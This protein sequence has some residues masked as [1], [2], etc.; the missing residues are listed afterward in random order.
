MTTTITLAQSEKH[1]A[2]LAATC[3]LIADRGLHNIPMSAIAKKAKMAAGTL[4][5]YFENKDVLINELFLYLKRESYNYIVQRVDTDQ[6]FDEWL[7]QMWFASARRHLDFPQAFNVI[8][9]CELSGILSPDTLQQQED[10]ETP[11]Y[12]KF[13]SAI[14]EGVIKNLP[15]QIVYALFM[16]PITILAHL[17][18]KGEIEISDDI[19]LQTY[20]QLKASI[21]A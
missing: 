19:L 13:Q 18:A 17:Q 21:K 8:Q 1:E 7:E 20:E 12:H 15:R 4:Y 3:E 6:S 5:L 10:I 9:Q 14:E 11:L 2:I 16:G